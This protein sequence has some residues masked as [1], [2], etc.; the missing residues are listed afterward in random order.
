MIYFFKFLVSKYILSILLKSNHSFRYVYNGK[1]LLNDLDYHL[2]QPYLQPSNFISRAWSSF[3]LLLDFSI[4]LYKGKSTLK[5][6]SG[7]N[8]HSDWI[9][10]E[11][12][13]SEHLSR[14]DLKSSLEQNIDLVSSKMIQFKLLS[15]LNYLLLTFNRS[16][17]S[18]LLFFLKSS[19]ENEISNI[20]KNLNSENFFNLS[21]YRVNP[22]LS[23]N[24]E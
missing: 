21:K 5:I 14:L 19:T 13:L 8:F 12:L 18:Q 2:F 3:N 11:K 9:I 20:T 17:R 16:L 24:T 10:F 23:Q 6:S 22:E 1:C 4:T 15:G 7:S